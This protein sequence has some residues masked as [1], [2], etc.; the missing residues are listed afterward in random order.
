MRGDFFDSNILIYAAGKDERAIRATS[1]MDGRGTISVQVLNE[2]VNVARR[3][4]ALEWPRI[5]YFLT[6][7]R[8]LLDVHP[9]DLETHDSALAL[10]ERY[11][12]STY[13]AV[14]VAS[15]LK[16]RC[17]RLYSEDMHHGLVIDGRLRIENP[18]LA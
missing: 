9:L 12:L 10:A 13:D 11:R 16:A 5:H 17:R 8:S 1:L 15:A 6:G 3:K 14:I 18:F 7:V 4:M 2:F